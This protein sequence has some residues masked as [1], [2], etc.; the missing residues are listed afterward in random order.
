MILLNKKRI[1][2]FV[3]IIFLLIMIY[4]M[5]FKQSDFS[6]SSTSDVA[7]MVS[8]MGVNKRTI[9]IDAGHRFT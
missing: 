2:L 7:V 3:L 9:I 6:I 4:I 1:I 5:C 8:N